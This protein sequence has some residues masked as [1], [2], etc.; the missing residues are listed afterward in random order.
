MLE[1]A[2]DIDPVEWYRRADSI[3]SR[4]FCLSSERRNLTAGSVAARR[5]LKTLN[6]LRPAELG[7]LHGA[8]LSDTEYASNI[9][10]IIDTGASFSLTPFMEDFVSVLDDPDVDELYG[11]SDSVAVKGSGW[12]E[13]KVR[14]S[15]GQIALVRTRAYFVPE[16][17]VRLLSPQVY[18]GMAGAGNCSF[19]SENVAI[20]A[21]NGAELNFEFEKTSKLPFMLLSEHAEFVGTS[22]TARIAL[23]TAESI[24]KVRNVLQDQN[25]NLAPWEKEVSL[26]HQRLGH[27]GVTWCQSLMKKKKGVLGSPEPPIIKTEFKKAATCKPPLCVACQLAKQF[28]RPTGDVVHK[29]VKAVEGAIRRRAEAPGDEVSCD[30][31]VCGLPRRLPHTRGREGPNDRYHGGTIFIDHYSRKIFLKCQVS[32]RV[33]ETLRAKEEFETLAAKDRVQLKSFR[34]DN[35]PFASA[36]F[37]ADIEAKEQTISHCGAGAH[38]QNGVSES[39]RPGSALLPDG[40]EP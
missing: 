11:P 22:N 5:I 18:F 29:K 14:D 28:R 24:S 9:P 33:G 7:G 3:S 10:I 31:F 13:W 26:V 30:Q 16:A 40:L 39:Q 35:H 2:D 15:T 4:Q 36:E 25:L 20:N 8:F 17:N 12:V 6:V 37:K 19:D 21:P 27:A 1:E 23:T 32:L 34:C 38:H